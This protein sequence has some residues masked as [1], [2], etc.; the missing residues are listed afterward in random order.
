MFLANIFD[1]IITDDLIPITIKKR[2]VN[3]IQVPREEI[4]NLVLDLL[5]AR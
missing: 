4:S 5:P 2:R 1:H 3:M